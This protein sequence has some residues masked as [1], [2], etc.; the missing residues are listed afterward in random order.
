MKKPKGPKVPAAKPKAKRWKARDVLNEIKARKVPTASGVEVHCKFDAIVPASELKLYPGNYKK[1]P[2]AQLDRFELVVAGYG[3]KKGNG[4]RRAIVVSKLSGLVTKG[5]G[6]AAMARRRGWDVPVEYQEYKSKAEEIRDL[7]AD[8]A[9]SEMAATDEDALRKL[10]EQLAPGDVQL[11]AVTADEFEKLLAEAEIPD[12]EFPITAKLHESYDYVMVFTTNAS[13]FV[14][15]QTL[16]GVQAE[17]SYKKTGVGLGRVVPF[18]RFIESLHANRHSIHV[19]GDNND[20]PQTP[21]KRSRGGPKKPG[22]GLPA[23][24][25]SKKRDRSS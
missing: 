20:H 6:A 5:N 9:L 4:W 3:Q 1:H 15:L 25:R 17:R 23:D 11:A 7:V 14:F 8:N 16:C 18:K 22:K 21:S 24:C 2:G 19:Q 13:D 10:L 12:A